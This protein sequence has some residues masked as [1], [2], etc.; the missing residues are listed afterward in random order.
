MPI[1]CIYPAHKRNF[2]KT[3]GPSPN[4]PYYADALPLRRTIARSARASRGS[5][6]S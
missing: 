3:D 6:R 5:K 2:W 4:N 1:V